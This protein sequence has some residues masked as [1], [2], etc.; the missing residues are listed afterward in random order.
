[1]LTNKDSKKYSEMIIEIKN[2]ILYDL[3]KIA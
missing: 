1:M 2:N 3:H